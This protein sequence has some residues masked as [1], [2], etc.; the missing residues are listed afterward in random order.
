VKKKVKSTPLLLLPEKTKRE[1]RATILGHIQ[2]GGSPMAFDRILASRMGSYAVELLK[3]GKSARC[4]GIQNGEM[5]DHDII[6]CLE[7]MQRPFRQD[8]YDLSEILF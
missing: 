8:L 4:I 3:S 1:T 2:R 5:V 6:E 7:K